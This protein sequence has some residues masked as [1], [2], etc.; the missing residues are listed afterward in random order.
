MHKQ[1]MEAALQQAYRGRGA[2]APNPSV[3]AV[4]VHNNKIIAEAWHQGAGT[5]HAEQCVLEQIGQKTRDVTLYVTLEPCNH[6]GRTPPCV[7]AIIEAGITCVVYGFKDPNPLVIANNTPRILQEKGIDVIHFPL[8]EIDELYQSYQFWTK[9]KKPW[10][11]AKIAHTLDGKIAEVDGKTVTLSNE[12]CAAFTHRQRSNTDVILTS[13]RT[14]INDNPSMNARLDNITKRKPVAILDA[15][16]SLPLDRKI[17]NTASHCHIYHDANIRVDTPQNNCSYYGV[18][19]LNGRLDLAAVIKHLGTIGFHD[20]WVEAGGCI[21]SALH[22]QGL[23]QRT[24]LYIVPGTLGA[25]A[26]PAYHGKNLF[27]RDHTISWQIQNDNIIACLDWKERPC[28][29]A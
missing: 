13:A 18:P 17:F 22:E 4:A 7:S 3:G 8:P 1:F 11:T 16:L 24:Y 10:I 27:H 23:V 6:W 12:H 29:Q 28:L 2:C 26:T 9:T 20:V 21:F 14:V 25:N 5:A 19:A 15:A